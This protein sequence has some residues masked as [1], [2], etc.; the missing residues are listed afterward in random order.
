MGVVALISLGL[1]WADFREHLVRPIADHP[2]HDDET[3]ATTDL[4]RSMAAGAGAASDGY[5]DLLEGKGASAP[6]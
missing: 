3:D 1:S 6:L 5:R 2:P 4:L